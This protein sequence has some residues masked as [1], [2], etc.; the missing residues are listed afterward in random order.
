MQISY[1]QKR[2]SGKNSRDV[3]EAA[4]T[5][6]VT[7]RASRAIWKG[8]RENKDDA[9]WAS[10]VFVGFYVYGF[11]KYRVGFDDVAVSKLSNLEPRFNVVADI[12][13]SQWREL[14]KVFEV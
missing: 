4:N 5:A 9:G 2:K 8:F 11:R 10:P 13:L 14:L 1:R 6:Q 3:S 7:Y 12:L